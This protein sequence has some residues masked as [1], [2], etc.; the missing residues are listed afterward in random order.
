MQKRDNGLL[1]RRVVDL[2]WYQQPGERG[3]RVGLFA[4]SIGNGNPEVGGHG[5][6]GRSRRLRDAVQVRPEVH[7][8]GVP[9]E[10]VRHFVLQRVDE[11][12]IADRVGGL[13][14]NAGHSLIALAPQAR[15]PTYRSARAHL[16]LPLRADFGQVIGPYEGSAAAVG[17]MHYDDLGVRQFRA[18]IGLLQLRIVPLL[19]LA[20]IDS[21]QR[22]GRELQLLGDTSDVVGGY[23]T[24]QNRG[25][26]QRLVLHLADLLVG[27]GHVR[28]AEVHG[29]FGELP[30]SSAGADRL[31]VD[32]RV[33]IRFAELVEPF[34]VDRI[35][36]RGARRV[37]QHL[38]L[39]YRQQNG[40]GA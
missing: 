10:T 5:L 16:G 24:A 6:G 33:R 32:L 4:G 23:Q 34:A 12:D 3:D 40:E 17:P 22:F 14:D 26:V 13:L 30:D 8:G 20:Q 37:D 38:G 2:R 28:R 21:R 35:R 29:A 39:R 36:E 15:G 27:H 7:P 18:G 31:V 19:D 9:H 11:F 1:L 25:E